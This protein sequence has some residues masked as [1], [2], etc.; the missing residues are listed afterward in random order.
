MSVNKRLALLAAMA[1]TTL[2]FAESENVLPAGVKAVW[3]LDK[4]FRSGTATREQVCLNGL[5]RWQ[6]GNKDKSDKLP[7][8]PWGYTKVPGSWAGS[9]QS[10][11]LHPTWKTIRPGD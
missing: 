1:T 8:E 5:W 10:H 9:G 3:D 6:P 4:A 7:T 11:F 2:C